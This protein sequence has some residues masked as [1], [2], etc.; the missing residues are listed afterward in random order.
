[1][2]NAFNIWKNANEIANISSKLTDEKKRILIGLLAK[3]TG[4][5][6]HN[7]LKLILAKFYVNSRLV[8]I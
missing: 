3:F 5:N 1:M 6:K 4:N 2:K 8:G 7:L